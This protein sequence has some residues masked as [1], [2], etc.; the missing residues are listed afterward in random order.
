MINRVHE[1]QDN[2]PITL[3][4]GSRSWVDSSAGEHIHKKRPNSFVQSHVI[5]QAGHHVYADRAA[6]FNRLIREACQFDEEE[7]VKIED[8]SSNE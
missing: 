3:L 1:I 7:K 2:V 6:E 4:Y 8:A 5:N